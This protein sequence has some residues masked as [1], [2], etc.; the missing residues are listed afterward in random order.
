VTGKVDLHTHVLPEALP[1]LDARY[2]VPG[3]VKLTHTGPGCAR[4][5]V[6]GEHFRDIDARSWDPGRRLAD[7][8]RDGVAAQ[9]L[10]TV[11]VLFSYWAPIE[12]AAFLA[13]R[14]NDHIAGLVRDHPGRFFGLGTVPLQD[15][16]RAIREL[17]RCMGPLG[18]QGVEIGT[19]V[20]AW[21]FD[22]PALFPFFERCAALGAAVFIHPWD[23][24]GRERMPRYMLPWLVGMPAETALAAASLVLGR[25][26]ERLPGLKVCL[27]HGGGSFPWTLGR[28]AHAW[29]AR[30]DLCA[31]D[32]A[33]DPWQSAK[34]FYY[35]S[36]LHDPEALRFLLARVGPERVALGTDYPFPLGEQRPGEGIE[37]MRDLPGPDVE[38]LLAGTAREF[39]GRT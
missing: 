22:E 26:L 7:C 34:R 18:L 37:S 38:R 20:N 35:D 1:D 24:M 21:N 9:V 25:V 11:P 33:A 28:I 32:G 2:G 5:T 39:L 8:E 12:A 19:H 4:M 13:E 30:P 17:E 29:S 10:S 15:P 6:N 27:A 14:L 16:E 31:I 23:M 3:F 36:L